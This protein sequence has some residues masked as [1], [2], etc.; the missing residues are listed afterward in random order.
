M[1]LSTLKG[2]IRSKECHIPGVNKHVLPMRVSHL[3]SL[4]VLL[5]V[6]RIELL[7][8]I[9]PLLEPSLLLLL[10]HHPLPVNNTIHQTCQTRRLKKIEIKLRGRSALAIFLQKKCIS[11]RK[12]GLIMR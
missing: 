5:N 2:L 3:I 6:L 1:K 12:T 9:R 11:V 10:H 7:N 4:M 8:G